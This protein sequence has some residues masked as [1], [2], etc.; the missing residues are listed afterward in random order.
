VLERITSG[1]EV[2]EGVVWVKSLGAELAAEVA[3]MWAE[4]MEH[5]ALGVMSE[6]V[7]VAAEV[8]TGEGVR[9]CIIG[10]ALCW[11]RQW[12]ILG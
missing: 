9:K 2:T 7:E 1:A 5:V 6:G 8:A 4:V 11:F 12:R 3:A 10:W